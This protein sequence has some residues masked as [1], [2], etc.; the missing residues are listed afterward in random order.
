MNVS[1]ET[2][3]AR[4]KRCNERNFNENICF[5]VIIDIIFIEIMPK[6]RKNRL[7]FNKTAVFE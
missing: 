6:Y 2:S 3:N 4:E 7:N 1:R 5:I